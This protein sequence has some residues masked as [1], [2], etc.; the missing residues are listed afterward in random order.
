MKA[1]V[2]DKS[3]TMR[4]VLSRMLSARGFEVMEAENGQQAMEALHGAGVADLILA[5]WSPHELEFVTSLRREAAGATVVIMLTTSELG[6]R[7]LQSALIAGADD[8]LVTPFTSLQMD[9]RLA[10]A[11]LICPCVEH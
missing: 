8:Y 9:E 6:T 4:A 10:R 3:Y 11:G 7:E 1:L 5:N 2:V